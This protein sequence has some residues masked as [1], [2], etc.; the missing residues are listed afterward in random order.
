M[1]SEK[2]TSVRLG[3]TI[4]GKIE[5]VMSIAALVLVGLPS[6]QGALKVPFM[7]AH[8]ILEGASSPRAACLP[9]YSFD[10]VR[11]V[12]AQAWRRRRRPPCSRDP[13]RQSCSFRLSFSCGKHALSPAVPA[14]AAHSRPFFM[15]QILRPSP[16]LLVLLLQVCWRCLIN[17]TS[18]IIHTHMLA[19]PVCKWLLMYR[20]LF[21]LCVDTCVHKLVGC[22]SCMVS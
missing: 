9:R 11:D 10:K 19:R 20:S 5:Y 21:S 14:H 15:L 17:S 13:P 12:R 1:Q 8:L 7:R 22:G 2:R 18:C 6:R 16:C 3:V 4:C